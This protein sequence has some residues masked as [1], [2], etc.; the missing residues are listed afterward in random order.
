MRP[1]S[2]EMAAEQAR[3]VELL[4]SFQDVIRIR[5]QAG[6][7]VF[8]SRHIPPGL[9]LVLDGAVAVLRGG[10]RED[11]PALGTLDAA[12]GAFFVPA[13]DELDQPAGAGVVVEREAEMLFIPRSL[14]LGATAVRRFLEND[15]RF[16]ALSLR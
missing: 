9:F 15:G 1:I 11:L 12:G 4:E 14:A 16:P 7:F 2:R 6:Q 8:Y 3:Q 5:A 10:G 13:L